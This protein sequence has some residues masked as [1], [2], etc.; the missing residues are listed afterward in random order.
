MDMKVT[1]TAV[2]DDRTWGF[3]ELL[4]GRAFCRAT[5]TEVEDLIRQDPVTILEKGKW[6]IEKA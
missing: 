5:E 2:L 4:C 3:S 1:I 6:T